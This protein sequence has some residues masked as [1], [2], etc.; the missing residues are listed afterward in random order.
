MKAIYSICA[1]WCP[2]LRRL[3]VVGESDMREEKQQKHTKG[4]DTH[5]N[6]RSWEAKEGAPQIPGQPGLV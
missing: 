2:E 6:L 5:H 4:R 1:E 3:S